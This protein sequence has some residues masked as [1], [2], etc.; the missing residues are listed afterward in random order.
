MAGAFASVF[1]TCT[2]ATHG[3]AVSAI[4]IRECRWG[5]GGLRCIG[6]DHFAPFARGV[7][8]R[9]LPCQSTIHMHETAERVSLGLRRTYAPSATVTRTRVVGLPRVCK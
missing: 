4:Q 6:A 9:A 5:R 8:D 2:I 7:T 3:L 1:S